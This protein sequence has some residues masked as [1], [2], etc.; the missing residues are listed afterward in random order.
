MLGNLSRVLPQSIY[1]PAETKLPFV[2][3]KTA[4]L[5]GLWRALVFISRLTVLFSLQLFQP[6]NF[7]VWADSKSWLT[8]G[9]GTAC[10]RANA[11]TTG[12]YRYRL[13]F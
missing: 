1:D 5:F 10:L 8:E 9:L 11:F 2:R 3:S 13:G 6:S 7:L 12:F 4:G